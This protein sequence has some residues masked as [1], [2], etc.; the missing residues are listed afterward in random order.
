MPTLI[1]RLRGLL[2]KKF[3]RDTLILQAGKIA[4]TLLSV[5]ALVIVIRLMGPDNYGVWRLVLA[6][7]GISQAFDLTGIGMATATR[8][9]L[10]IGKGDEPEI[11]NLLAVYV[12]VGLAWALL[13]ALALFT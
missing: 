8:L 10:A 3:V 9:A 4:N 2:R 12:K 6:L 5:I 1:S 11:L 7:F 13:T